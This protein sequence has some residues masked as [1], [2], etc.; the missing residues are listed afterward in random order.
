MAIPRKISLSTS[1]SSLSTGAGTDSGLKSDLCHRQLFLHMNESASKSS[2]SLPSFSGVEDGDK[3]KKGVRN[4]DRNVDESPPSTVR[5]CVVTIPIETEST[6]SLEEKTLLKSFNNESL[7]FK[8]NANGNGK[9]HD[10]SESKRS[11]NDMKDIV[12][13]D[14]SIAHIAARSDFR[15]RRRK[16]KH[17]NHSSIPQEAADRLRNFT[18]S[19]NEPPTIVTASMNSHYVPPRLLFGIGSS[20]GDA[21]PKNNSCDKGA[22]NRVS[23]HMLNSVGLEC[24]DDGKLILERFEDDDNASV[25]IHDSDG[26]GP[27]KT[28]GETG[29]SSKLPQKH[30]PPHKPPM[31]T[32][33]QHKAFVAA[34]FEIGLKNCS[35]SIIMENMRKQP[36]YITRER[37]KSHLQKYRQTKERSKAEF[38]KE[39]DDFF[40]STEKA[41][42]MLKTKDSNSCLND[43]KKSTGTSKNFKHDEPIPKV[44]LTAALEG[45]KPGR[46]L[47]GKAAALLSYSVIN[48][49]STNHGPDQL[50]YK[51]AKLSEFPLMTEE[52]KR[53]SVGSSLLQVKSLIDN[54]TDILLKTRHGIKPFPVQRS[55]IGDDESDSS[56]V[57]SSDDGYSD[58]DED[59]TDRARSLERH[60]MGK[61]AS[62]DLDQV[63]TANSTSKLG[64]S[65][66]ISAVP[67]GPA[68]PMYRG[69]PI[70]YPAPF[71]AQGAPPAVA[72]GFPPPQYPPAQPSYYGG[73]HPHLQP[74]TAP[75]FGGPPS[76]HHP[77]MRYAQDPRLNPYQQAPPPQVAT[78]PTVPPMPPNYFPAVATYPTYYGSTGESVMNSGTSTVNAEYPHHPAVSSDVFTN[79]LSHGSDDPRQQ[80]SSYDQQSSSY[81]NDGRT[82]RRKYD[83]H[84][85]S[86]EKRSRGRSERRSKHRRIRDDRETLLSIDSSDFQENPDDMNDFLDRL[87]KVPSPDKSSR[88]SSSSPIQRS[89]REGRYK[90]SPPMHSEDSLIKPSSRERSRHLEEQKHPEPRRRYQPQF[91]TTESHAKKYSSPEADHFSEGGSSRFSN[92]YGTSPVH[93]SPSEKNQN[94]PRVDRQHH[95]NNDGHFW[96]SSNFEEAGYNNQPPQSDT[97]GGEFAQQ[98]AQL[99]SFVS[100]SQQL[101][102]QQH[103]GYSIVDGEQHE[104]SDGPVYI[105]GAQSSPNAGSTTNYFFG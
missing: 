73:T 69:P 70:V 63:T 76:F 62:K 39:F 56:S 101:E 14:D 75:S 1:S 92:T 91:D 48:G 45:K 37:T 49:F 24:G 22:K 104:N 83:S 25:N 32:L 23:V 52:E 65:F 43:N 59:N 34:I 19:I 97:A 38:L 36:R 7:K 90:S 2:V 11:S 93:R 84:E 64:E 68:H 71:A 61:T 42:A 88:N 35:P 82:D 96:E 47:C 50:Q 29:Q 80:T 30:K 5:S 4:T 54:M 33:A 46:L 102:E 105:K 57:W 99:H 27:I 41:E 21:F 3:S 15:S 74:P 103:S 78:Y 6:K 8:V 17:K 44:V 51:A 79:H 9:P 95:N 85:S 12:N 10:D 87:S 81:S 26:A 66:P 16:W 100:E 72:P 89:R 67:V 13:I 40:R 20:R 55:E 31:W 53:T 77:Q 86:K 98:P 28:E 58:E 60:M 18:P 94:Q